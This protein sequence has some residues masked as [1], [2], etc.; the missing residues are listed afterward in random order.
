MLNDDMN[1]RTDLNR[2]DGGMGGIMIAALV[3][4][5]VIIGLV[6]WAPWKGEHTASNT[7]PNTTVGSSANRPAAP[8]S[9]TTAPAPASPS[10]SK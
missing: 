9:P 8:A 4:A 3:A 2:R 1:R 5:A 7:S 10:T 6:M